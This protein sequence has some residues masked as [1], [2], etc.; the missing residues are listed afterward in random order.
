MQKR[1]T[2]DISEVTY[3]Y[4]KAGKKIRGSSVSFE[5]N[6]L[7]EF[8]MKEKHRKKKTVPLEGG[9]EKNI[10]ISDNPPVGNKSESRG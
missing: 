10:Q 5:A 9:A 1:I 7:I 3:E 2:V 4:L 8:A 6:A